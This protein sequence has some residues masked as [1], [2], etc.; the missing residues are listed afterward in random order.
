M[1]EGE[2]CHCTQYHALI[3]T[4]TS[5]VPLSILHF[6]SN[7]LDVAGAC[8]GCRSTD[9]C[10]SSGTPNNFAVIS[11]MSIISLMSAMQSSHAKLLLF[12]RFVAEQ[13]IFMY[14]I[15]NNCFSLVQSTALKNPR[16]REYLDFAKPPSPTPAPTTPLPP[17]A[18]S[19]SE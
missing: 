6:S 4:A 7:L 15:T 1:R 3:S 10:L 19:P 12:L 5:I 17:P 8:C 14:W 2:C 9:L 11:V 16:L 13:G 18:I